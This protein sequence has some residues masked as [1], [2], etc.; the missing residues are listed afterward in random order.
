MADGKFYIT[1][2][3]TRTTATN[4]AGTTLANMF[5][6]GADSGINRS[7][8]INDAVFGDMNSAMNEQYESALKWNKWAGA[9]M[10][11]TGLNIAKQSVNFF[12]SNYGNITGDYQ[13]QEQL[14]YNLSLLQSALTIGGSAIAGFMWGGPV[15]AVVGLS[16]GVLTQVVKYGFENYERYIEQQKSNYETAILRARSGLDSINNS[17]RGT[18][19]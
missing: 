6:N 5:G 18:E 9:Q 12:V 11:A 15:G 7:S 16:L 3:D 1:I 10:L 19:Y 2:S 8:N 17:S 13:T 14:N 4:Q